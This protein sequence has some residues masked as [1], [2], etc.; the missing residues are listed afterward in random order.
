[1]SE[2]AHETR[3]VFIDSETGDIQT[4]IEQWRPILNG[5]PLYAT[6]QEIEDAINVIYSTI[7]LD[8]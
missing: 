6:Q 8:P 3:Y 4:F 7:H 5:Q 2:F 1:M